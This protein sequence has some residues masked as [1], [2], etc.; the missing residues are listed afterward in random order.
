MAHGPLPSSM[1]STGLTTDRLSVAQCEY[2]IFSCEYVFW[3][4]N[5]WY[6]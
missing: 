6:S 5:I 2:E 4:M 3:S 1:W